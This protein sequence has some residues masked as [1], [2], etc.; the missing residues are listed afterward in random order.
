MKKAIITPTIPKQK[1]DGFNKK[2]MGGGVIDKGIARQGSEN[3]H[4]EGYKLGT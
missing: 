4:L 1:Q 2:R 3:M